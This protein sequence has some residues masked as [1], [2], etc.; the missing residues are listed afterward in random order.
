MTVD[1]AEHTR[2]VKEELVFQRMLRLHVL[3]RGRQGERGVIPEKVA[4]PGEVD[5]AEKPKTGLC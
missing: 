3:V 4:T 5:T 2:V 1:P